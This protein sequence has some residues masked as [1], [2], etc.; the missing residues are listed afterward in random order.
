MSIR[1][2]LIEE[3]RRLDEIIAMAMDDL[4]KAPEGSLSS[5][6]N[7]GKVY[8]YLHTGTRVVYLSRNRDMA[9]IRALTQKAYARK[10]IR[11]ACR[12]KAILDRFLADY[13]PQAVSGVFVDGRHDGMFSPYVGKPLEGEP[14]SFRPAPVLDP[15]LVSQMRDL[16]HRILEN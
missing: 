7:R 15:E 3:G 6:R 12:Q 4:G 9:R 5:R 2:V 13:D 11:I 8:F 1:D 10:I 14:F 16:C